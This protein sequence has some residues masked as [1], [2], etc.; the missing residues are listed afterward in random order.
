MDKSTL[1]R[2]LLGKSEPGDLIPRKAT[3]TDLP[4]LVKLATH[5][6]P[7][8]DLGNAERFAQR[9][10]EHPEYAAIFISGT[11][12]VV[13][14]WQVEIW[15]P[16]QRI[17]IAGPIFSIP[18]SANPNGLILTLRAVMDWARS[19]NCAELRIASE[20]GAKRGHATTDFD[21][22]APVASRLG[23]TLCKVEYAIPL[24]V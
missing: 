7:E 21:V 22:F 2:A 5:C 1:S 19:F 3:L 11:T 17:A 10:L 12:V 13:A 8:F 15:A 18:N 6:Y 20:K 16:T 23:A 4:F 9:L 24:E 14:Y